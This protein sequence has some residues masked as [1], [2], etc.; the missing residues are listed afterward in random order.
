MKH[1]RGST[2]RADAV[3]NQARILDVAQA[4][5]A[6]D[7]LELEMHV[8]AA[9]A[10]LGVGTLYSHFAN[11]EELLRA[12]VQRVVEDALAQLR[13]APASHADDP[14]AALQALVSAGLHVLQQYRPL[15]AVIRDP[16]LEKLLDPSYGQA[17][18]AQFL[19]IPRE[20]IDRGIQ[21]GIFRKGLDREMAMVTIMGTFPSAIDLLGMHCSLDELTQR[22]SHFLV[23]LFAG[24]IEA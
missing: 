1:S 23:T 10:H 19:E 13:A 5:F 3:T 8:V 4:V 6:E 22:L 7:G 18:R 21:A 12:I 9:R 11:R 24:K 17:M 15:F 16:R 2:K 20:L 14:R